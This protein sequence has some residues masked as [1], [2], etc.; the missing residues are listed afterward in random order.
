M[1]DR[2]LCGSDRS[3]VP[4]EQ[5]ESVHQK[6]LATLTVLVALIAIVSVGVTLAG[7]NAAPSAQKGWTA[8][9]GPDGHPD[10]SGTWEHNAATPLE[11]PDELAGR[12][13]LTDSEVAQIKQK[14]AELFNGDG[15]AAFGD[16][17]Y[18]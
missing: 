9:R 17:I 6:R 10:I 8:P 15:D 18:L 5:E 12:A 3:L 11:R 1:M 2:I 16:A 14:A 13:L 7:Q 4:D